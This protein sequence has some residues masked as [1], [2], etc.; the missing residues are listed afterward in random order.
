MPPE[1]SRPTVFIDRNSG[2]RLFKAL[3]KA[4]GIP[5]VL[6]DERFPDTTEDHDWLAKLGTSGWLLVTGDDDTTRTP[7]FLHQLAES[8]AHV[9]MLRGL[10]GGS[11]EDKARCIVDAYPK[12]CELAASNEPPTFWRIGKKDGIARAFDFRATLKKMNQSKRR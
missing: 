1:A 12:M 11:R 6:H 4:A 5:V 8:R 7:L 2:G 3:I 10:N 9:F